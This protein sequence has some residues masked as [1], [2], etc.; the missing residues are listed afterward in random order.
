MSCQEAVTT[1]SRQHSQLPRCVA[2]LFNL[3]P[4]TFLFVCTRGRG[5]YHRIGYLGP[6]PLFSPLNSI[7]ASLWLI[8][9]SELLRMIPEPDRAVP[10]YG[11]PGIKARSLS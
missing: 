5:V 1:N 3:P 11:Q 10:H 9:G 7:Q 2:W 8:R 6:V 4:T